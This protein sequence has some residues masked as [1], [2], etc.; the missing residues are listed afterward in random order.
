M[1]GRDLH[2]P[3]FQFEIMRSRRNYASPDNYCSHPSSLFLSRAVYFVYLRFELPR[4]C[5]QTLL[6][7]IWR[8]CICIRSRRAVL[9]KKLAP[10]AF[11]GWYVDLFI[12]AVRAQLRPVD[13]MQ[14]RITRG[15]KLSGGIVGSSRV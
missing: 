12:N 1:A 14:M 13:V 2:N 7:Y 10:R 11:G 15:K 3:G 9:Q 4:E 5:K 6:A 8:L